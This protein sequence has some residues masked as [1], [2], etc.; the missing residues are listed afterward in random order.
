MRNET[1]VRIVAIVYK[2]IEGRPS[3]RNEI[4]ILDTSATVFNATLK[5]Y[6]PRVQKM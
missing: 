2:Y 5:T 6:N 3:T 4:P 1:L